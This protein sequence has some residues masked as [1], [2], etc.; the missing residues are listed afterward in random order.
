M[1]NDDFKPMIEKSNATFAKYS[2]TKKTFAYQFMTDATNMTEVDY[3][4]TNQEEFNVMKFDVDASIDTRY[5]FSYLPVVPRYIRNFKL[6]IVAASVSVVH[7][8][9]NSGK[10]TQNSFINV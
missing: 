4:W 3:V 9:L 10:L 1:G 5:T 7:Y 2:Y 8:K 6:G